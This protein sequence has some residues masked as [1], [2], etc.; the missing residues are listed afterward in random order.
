MPAA[1]ADVMQD[2]MIPNISGLK[3][4]G[5]FCN[6]LTNLDSMDGSA[7]RLPAALDHPK[8]VMLD[9]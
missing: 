5:N 6:R 9:A 1:T 7:D 8:L 3:R 2:W 4:F